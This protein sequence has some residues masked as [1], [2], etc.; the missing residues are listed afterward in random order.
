MG[1]VSLGPLV[2]GADRFAVLLAAIVFL[3]AAETMGRALEP[4]LG[5]WAWRALLAFAAGAR[6]GHVLQHAGSFGQE[7]WRIVAFWQGGFYWPTGVLGIAL[8]SFLYLRDRR[9]L[10]LSLAPVTISALVGLMAFSQLAATSQIGLPAGA[11]AT[12]SGDHLSARELKGMPMVVN[13]WASWCPPCRREMPMMAQSAKTTEGVKFVFVNQAESGARVSSFLNEQKIDLET[14]ILD[15][16]SQFAS[17]YTVPGL[18]ATLFIDGGGNLRSVTFG[19]IISGDGCR[20]PDY[21]RQ[22]EPIAIC[23]VEWSKHCER[24]FNRPCTDA[25]VDW[26]GSSEALSLNLQ[27]LRRSTCREGGN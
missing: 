3:I 6:L 23:L 15:L 4:R 14:V 26:P 11:F 21:E 1:A 18:P 25:A 27:L 17:H 13:L 9:V 7:P 20:R 24:R 2:F 19:E 22:D 10:A 5:S 16:A 12:L 8:V